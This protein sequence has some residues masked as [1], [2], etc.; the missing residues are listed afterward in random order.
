MPKIEYI[1]KG[2][3]VINYPKKRSSG[4]WK[5]FFIVIISLLVG[6]VGGV[7]SIIVL[8]RDGGAIAKKL[9]F[10]NWD[11]YTIPLTET[12]KIKIEE[13]NAIIDSVKLARH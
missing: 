13:S 5:I 8:S 9:G 1:N 6:S 2:D 7:G 12:K 10:K 11:S 3:E 4:F